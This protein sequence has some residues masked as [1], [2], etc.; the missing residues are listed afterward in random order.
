[1]TRDW[2]EAA[3]AAG[4]SFAAPLDVS[5]LAVHPEVRA[6][7]GEDRCNKYGKCW[8][9]PPGCGTLETCL[10]RMRSFPS[11][12]LVQSLFPLE[13]PLDYAAMLQAE[14]SHHRSFLT[15]RRL[16]AQA[17][18]GLLALGSGGCR[19][20]PICAYPAAPCRF[21]E[22]AVSSMEAYGLLVAEVCK[23]NS[24]GYYY[25]PGSISFTGC[26]LF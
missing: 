21:P 5:T 18:P 23:A 11:G 8:T 19:L 7:C 22:R 6:M 17:H 9:C 26:Y 4:F 10:A 25:G 12:L 24:M 13:D 2:T 1:M 14:A 3:L 15:F 16:L 20:C